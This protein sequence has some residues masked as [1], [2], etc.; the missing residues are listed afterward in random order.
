MEN[1]Y[2]LTVWVCCQPLHPEDVHFY[3]QSTGDPV[4]VTWCCHQKLNTQDFENWSWF[5]VLFTLATSQNYYVK[6]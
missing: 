5:C 3:L 2:V 1:S 6:E 4:T